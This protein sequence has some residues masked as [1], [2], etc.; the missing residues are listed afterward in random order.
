MAKRMQH[1]RFSGVVFVALVGLSSIVGSR[2]AWAGMV[3]IASEGE[4]PVAA[5]PTLQALSNTLDGL[6]LS[7]QP[8]S[9][10]IALGQAEPLPAVVDATLTVKD[11][12]AQIEN[13]YRL[14]LRGEFAEAEA[15]LSAAMAA[16]ARNPGTVVADAAFRA[17]EQPVT[18]AQFGPEADQF[19]QQVRRKLDSTPRGRLIVDVTRS[20]AQIFINEQGRAKG[21]AFSSDV[22]PGLYRIMVQV[23]GEARR[24]VVVIKGD[25]E[26]RLSIDW[27][28]SQY[29][30]STPAGLMLKLPVGALPT[31]AVVTRS[32][33]QAAGFPSGTFVLLAV[34]PATKSITIVGSVVGVDSARVLRA[35]RITVGSDNRQ[36]VQ[37]LAAYLATGEMNESVELVG[38]EKTSGP[39]GNLV[40]P[41]P[42]ASTSAV[43]GPP[44]IAPPA[45]PPVLAVAPLKMRNVSIEPGAW[46]D[47][48]QVDAA[49]A[50]HFGQRAGYAWL[51]AGTGLVALAG[52]VT[53]AYLFKL[54][55][56]PTCRAGIAQCPD[57]DATAWAG[58]AALAG[59]GALAVVSGVFT[60]AWLTSGYRTS[61]IAL[62]PLGDGGLATFNGRF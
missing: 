46:V 56:T 61:L 20:N 48:A 29:V 57:L 33:L 6:G 24:Y 4:V 39:S 44:V 58:Y 32:F 12:F 21:A 25:A 36:R 19:Y 41:A 37:H 14:W 13:G 50:P 9:I 51:A 31:A 16:I 10:A 43:V 30:Y 34:V 28:A 1:R 8:A 52:L 27:N 40:A 54:D 62:L 18:S 49:A 15:Q 11:L 3:V 38:P 7:A 60:Y 35:A 2:A 53:G 45:K 22:L 55:G 47:S 42:P 59:G 17:A 26:T 23:A 5:V